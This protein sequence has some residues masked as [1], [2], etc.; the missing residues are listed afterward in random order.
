M[1]DGGGIAPSMHT[2]SDSHVI[3]EERTWKDLCYI[4]QAHERLPLGVHESLLGR[5][6]RSI[7]CQVG[8]KS[9]RSGL[10]FGLDYNGPGTGYGHLV[11]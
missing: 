9:E 11:R 7:S 6:I 2:L 3:S 4:P 5:E 8:G 10:R 1:Y